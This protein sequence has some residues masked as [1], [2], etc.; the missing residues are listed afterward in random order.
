MSYYTFLI[1][2]IVQVS[3]ADFFTSASVT[4]SLLPQ[5]TIAIPLGMKNVILA[6]AC[7]LLDLNFAPVWL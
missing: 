5:L 3:V 1:Q 2:F 4:E 6:L 7:R